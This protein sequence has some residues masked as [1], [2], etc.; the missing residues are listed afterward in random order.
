MTVDD[1]PD[2]VLMASVTYL[3]AFRQ[4]GPPVGAHAPVMDT[5][6]VPWSHTGPPVLSRH[7]HQW[8][9]D[10]WDKSISSLAAPPVLPQV[11]S[12]GEK[13][14]GGDVPGARGL[15]WGRMLRGSQIG[16]PNWRNLM[17]SSWWWPKPNDCNCEIHEWKVEPIYWPWWWIYM[18]YYFTIFI[19][20]CQIKI[21]D[22]IIM[23]HSSS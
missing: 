8:E 10:S 3:G 21:F 15:V 11:S 12:S 9:G 13:D 23:K 7:H 19:S 17:A 20:V 6:R 5:V 4:H 14:G 2:E 16:V 22:R 1:H 18:Y